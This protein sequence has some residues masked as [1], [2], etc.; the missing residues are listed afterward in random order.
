MGQIFHGYVSHNQMVYP[1]NIP[2]NHYKVH[3]KTPWKYPILGNLH[4]SGQ[5][6]TTSLWPHWEWW[7]VREI[8]P[9]WPQFRLVKYY[10]LPSLMGN[11]GQMTFKWGFHHHWYLVAH[12][13]ARK[14]VITPIISGWTLQKYHVN[15]WG[16]L[17]HNHEPW[18]VRHQVYPPKIP[19]HSQ[20]MNMIVG[21]LVEVVG[22]VAA[23][24]QEASTRKSLLESLHKARPL[25]IREFI[26][27][28][29]C[30]MWENH[31]N[32][33]QNP[34]QMQVWMGKL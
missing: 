28:I 32:I 17:T 30:K 7:L 4:I 29:P 13:T 31:R 15:H 18:V 3:Y 33:W 11:H 22:I 24:E 25:G 19:R 12:P 2:L 1:M 5:I 23:A 6:I 14:W 34:L 9:K 20:V 10:N 21:V 8:I 16:E 27:Q 26:R